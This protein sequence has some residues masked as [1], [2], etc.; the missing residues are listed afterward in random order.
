MNFTLSTGCGY[1]LCA[2]ACGVLGGGG[3]ALNFIPQPFC[4]VR[5]GVH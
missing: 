1:G 4:I 2:L 3:Q 5:D